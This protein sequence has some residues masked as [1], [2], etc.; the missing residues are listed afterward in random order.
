M[1]TEFV[2][3]GGCCVLLPGMREARD[4]R[5]S[6]ATSTR[7]TR[8]REPDPRQHVLNRDG[9]LRRFRS[10]ALGEAFVGAWASPAF[11]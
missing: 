4:G 9:K 11:E 3:A 7:N 6:R 10:V 5:P 8:C 1:N 2:Q